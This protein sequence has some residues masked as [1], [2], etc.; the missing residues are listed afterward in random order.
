VGGG[1]KRVVGMRV[2][3]ERDQGRTQV[4]LTRGQTACGH[5]CDKREAGSDPNRV[6]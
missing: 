2:T 1:G 3:R 5:A 6:D 4:E